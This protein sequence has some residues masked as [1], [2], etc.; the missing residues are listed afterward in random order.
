MKTLFSSSL[1][2][3]IGLAFFYYTRGNSNFTLFFSGVS[4]GLIVGFS[5]SYFKKTP[6][7]EQS[8]QSGV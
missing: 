8:R 5:I 4:V 7:P 1:G 6:N 2:L 3:F